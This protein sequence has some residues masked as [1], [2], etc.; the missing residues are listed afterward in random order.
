MF[1]LN[2]KLAHFDYLKTYFLI[3]KFVSVETPFS[4]FVP[5]DETTYVLLKFVSNISRLCFC[6]ET[7]PNH[8]N[9]RYEIIEK[10][11]RP[12]G[13]ISCVRRVRLSSVGGCF[14]FVRSFKSLFSFVMEVRQRTPKF[15]CLEFQPFYCLFALFVLKYKPRFTFQPSLYAYWNN[16]LAC[17]CFHRK[18]CK[19]FY[20]N[21]Q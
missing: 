6:I 19:L 3:R 21:C 10:K 9:K 4:L 7:H 11:Q 20:P 1:R 8:Q 18:H 12:V 16:G 17:K 5:T 13:W 14:I 2:L 15:L